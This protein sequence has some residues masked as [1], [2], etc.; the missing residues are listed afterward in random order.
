MMSGY[1][2]LFFSTL[3]EFSI[4]AKLNINDKL[5]SEYFEEG[6]FQ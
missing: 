6:A 5:F 3:N 2:L 1:G 4:V